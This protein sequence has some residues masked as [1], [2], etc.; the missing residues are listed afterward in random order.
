MKRSFEVL[1]APRHL[2]SLANIIRRY[3]SWSSGTPRPRSYDYDYEQNRNQSNQVNGDVR[4]H[5]GRR[6]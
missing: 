3:V 2:E 4:S 1:S 5:V 6:I